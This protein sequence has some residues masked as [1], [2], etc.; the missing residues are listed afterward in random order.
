[1][2]VLFGPSLLSFHC[3]RV[4]KCCLTYC[5]NHSP[6]FVSYALTLQLGAKFYWEDFIS[7]H[8]PLQTF[9]QWSKRKSTTFWSMCFIFQLIC[10]VWWHW[11]SSKTAFSFAIR[12]ALDSCFLL[13]DVKGAYSG[14]NKTDLKWHLPVSLRRP[15]DHVRVSSAARHLCE[16]HSL[17]KYK[18]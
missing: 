12:E 5:W 6:A 7:S 9:F 3:R 16:H 4:L 15:L 17:Q 2:Y 11:I 10:E 14:R 18:P 8:F 13:H 1:M